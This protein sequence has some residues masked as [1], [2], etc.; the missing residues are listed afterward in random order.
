MGARCMEVSCYLFS[1]CGGPLSP[2]GD[3]FTVFSLC[4]GTFWSLWR[5]VGGWL[6][7]ASPPKKYT[8]T[9]SLPGRCNIVHVCINRKI[10]V[11]YSFYFTVTSSHL[12]IHSNIVTENPINNVK[13]QME[14]SKSHSASCL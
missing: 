9:V 1:P 3:P 5:G 13:L 12:C 14:R 10:L 8:L 2:C 11:L 7:W 6:F 4:G